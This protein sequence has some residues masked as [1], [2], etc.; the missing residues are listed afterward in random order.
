MRVIERCR[1]ERGEERARESERKKLQQ[2]ESQEEEGECAAS[3]QYFHA[4]I[5]GLCEHTMGCIGSRR[6]SK[7]RFSSLCC[8]RLGVGGW[9]WEDG[10][11]AGVMV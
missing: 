8:C 5:Q 11:L 4:C 6:L 9:G 10:V 1:S 3:G 2:K 7:P